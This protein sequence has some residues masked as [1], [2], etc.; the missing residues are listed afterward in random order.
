VPLV[1]SLPPVQRRMHG[2]LTEDDITYRGGPLTDG[3][4]S[5]HGVRSGDGFPDVPLRFP[6]GPGSSYRL[7]RGAEATLV[8]ADGAESGDSD[9]AFGDAGGFPVTVRRI[10]PGL[11]AED[12]EGRLAEALGA[13]A[14]LVRPDG[15]VATLADEP[16]A[17]RAWI[18]ERLV[19]E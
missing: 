15:V 10:G 2:F 14:A 18:A 4:G 3:S 1:L 12:P 6:E 16:A 19:R 11:D 8:L 17:A 5:R 7:L 13:R 9:L